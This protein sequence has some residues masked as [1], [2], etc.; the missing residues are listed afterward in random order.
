LRRLDWT[1]RPTRWS[2]WGVAGARAAPVSFHCNVEEALAAGATDEEIVGA[3]IAV[4]P[5]IGVARVI[6]ATPEVALPMGHDIDAAL[7]TR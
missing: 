1:P 7:E 4:A 6:S 2:A 3:L 5:I